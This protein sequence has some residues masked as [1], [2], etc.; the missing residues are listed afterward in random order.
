MT[1]KHGPTIDEKLKQMQD[2]KKFLETAFHGLN[3][4]AIVAMTDLEGT[5][6]FV[7]DRFIEISG[8]SAQ[9]LVG[10]NHRLINSG[11]HPKEFF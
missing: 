7:N 10:S 11:H 9:E 4:A 2:E 5:I 3:E 8:Y 6:T 1:Q